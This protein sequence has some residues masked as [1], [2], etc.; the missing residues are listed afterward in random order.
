MRFSAND[1]PKRTKWIPRPSRKLGNDSVAV[2]QGTGNEILQADREK[3]NP[4]D[5]WNARH[6]NPVS[7]VFHALARRATVVFFQSSA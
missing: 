6:P 5:P 3:S 1:R 2:V 4:I 7:S